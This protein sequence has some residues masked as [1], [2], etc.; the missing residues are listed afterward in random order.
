MPQAGE[1]ADSSVD[2][3][4]AAILQREIAGGGPRLDDEAQPWIFDA[5]IAGGEGRR[6]HGGARTAARSAKRLTSGP[7]AGVDDGAGVLRLDVGIGGPFFRL[8]N[9]LSTSTTAITL[10][11]LG[12]IQMITPPIVWS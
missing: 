3:L 7:R 4:V 5:D 6:R 9:M 8:R 2:R 10:I 12:G 11:M 1:L